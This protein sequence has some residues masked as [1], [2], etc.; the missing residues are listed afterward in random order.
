M[1]RA[2]LLGGICAVG[3]LCVEPA[4]AQARDLQTPYAFDI[5]GPALDQALLELARQSGLQVISSGASV[6]GKAIQPLRAT[7]PV[8][9]ALGQLLAGTNLGYQVTGP[10]TVTI[11]L[12]PG[13]RPRRPARPVGPGLSRPPLLSPTEF[14]EVVVTATRVEMNVNRVPLSI[15]AYTGARMDVQGIRSVDDVT[16]MTPGV[17]FSRNSNLSGNVSIRGVSSNVGSST[18]GIYLDD[19]PIQNRA[20]GSNPRNVFPRTFDMDRIEILRG[21]QGTLFGAGA[22]G[23]AIRFIT[24]KASVDTLSATARAELAFTDNGAPSWEAGVA[25]GGPV[26]KDKLG[27]RVGL[28]QRRDGGFVDRRRYLVP[29]DPTRTVDQRD[30]NHLD[31]TNLRLSMAWK[32]VDWLT[33]TPSIDAARMSSHDTL[34]AWAKTSDASRR[35]YRTGNGQPTTNLDK[36]VLSSLTLEADLGWAKLN[37]TTSNFFRRETGY[38]DY[39]VYMAGNFTPDGNLDPWMADPGY[40][41]DNYSGNKNN[42]YTQEIRL[43]STDP[44]ARLSWVVGAY[45]GRIRQ[46][47]QQRVRDPFLDDYVRA[48]S[49]E[50]VYGHPYLAGGIAYAE[51]INTH[52]DQEAVFGEANFNL[53]RRVKV[54]GGLRYSIARFDFT[55][56]AFGPMASGP[57]GL[58]SGGKSRETPLTPKIGVQFDLGDNNMIYGT[59]AKGFRVGGANRLIPRDPRCDAVLSALGLLEAPVS[60]NSDSLWSYEIGVKGRSPNEQLRWSGAAYYIEWNNIIR[61][62][63]G[64]SGCPYSMIA[65]LGDARSQGFDLQVDWFASRRLQVNLTV[66]YNSAKTKSTI[67]V[68]GAVQDLVTKGHTLGGNPWTV[69]VAAYYEF[70][71]PWVGAPG[72]VRA[73]YT[74]RSV[75]TGSRPETDPRY[76]RNYDPLYSFD[77]P[78]RE[79]RMRAGVKTPSGL[80]LSLFVNNL[81]NDNPVNDSRTNNRTNIF[82]YTPA[83]PRTVGMTAVYQY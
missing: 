35:D 47:S 17:N 75:N 30:A 48:P 20:V 82:V 8:G 15:A 6:R 49:I 74:Y 28:Y 70:R 71:T 73:D 37:S 41:S 42:I 63:S 24:N 29:R 59:A 69:N 5:A 79:L 80:N 27:F 21:P 43:A 3:V 44:E 78:T 67:R 51:N 61:N 65:N 50:A 83:R 81:L 68:P 10:G 40:F 26:V 2:G 31:T 32:P 58:R 12:A 57:A 72:Y 22:Q 53:S 13:A 45:V 76:P 33:A 36:Y 56:H 77:D 62:V 9:Q 38:Y 16:R 39:V 14:E 11:V 19:T 46:S 23:G 60:Y 54:V 25:T 1:A 66:G 52:E 34:S 55:G 18:T 7:L 4:H 64:R